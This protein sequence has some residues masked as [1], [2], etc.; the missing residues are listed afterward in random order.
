MSD[1]TRRTGVEILTL[2]VRRLVAEPGPASL[3]ALAETLGVPRSTLYAVARELVDRGWLVQPR[4]GFVALGRRWLDLAFRAPPEVPLPR[5]GAPEPPAARSF[6]W[7]PEVAGLVETPS[8]AKPPPWRI[9]FSNASRS[10]PWRRGLLGAIE[11]RVAAA[12]DIAAF[13]VAH[14]DD[15]IAAQARDIARLAASGIDALMVSPVA[16]HGLEDAL[17]AVRRRGLPV[18][19]V[20]RT[21]ADPD[22]YHVVVAGP[23]AAMGRVTAQWLVETIGGT[24]EI[25]LLAGVHE[26]SPAMRRLAAASEVFALAPGIRILDA[27]HTDWTPEGGYRVMRRLLDEGRARHVAGVWCDSGLQG[28]GSMRAF[29]EAGAGRVPPH[30]G[31]DLNEAYQ[32]AVRHAVPLAA[33]DYPVSIGS[34]AVEVCMEIL[35]GR[36]VPRRVEIHA[37]VVVSRGHDTASVRGDVAVEDHVAWARPASDVLGDTLLAAEA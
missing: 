31:G 5:R 15:D 28:A 8:F 11:R 9:G 13:E 25:V 33:I 12:A 16:A 1:G 24:G 22:A 2:L 19:M 14:A 36:T 37:P 35:S 27:V 21:V 26:A 29:V 4:R 7:N 6:L 3:P 18:V 17:E 32:L 10:N 30:T 34:R 20:D 23:D